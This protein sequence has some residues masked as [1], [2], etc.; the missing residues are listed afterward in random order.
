MCTSETEARSR[1]SRNQTPVLG[2]VISCQA[3]KAHWILAQWRGTV[4]IQEAEG[5]R[6]LN[7]MGSVPPVLSLSWE[8]SERRLEPS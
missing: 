8:A 5:F 4:F 6:F 3:R 2:H 1:C 7:V